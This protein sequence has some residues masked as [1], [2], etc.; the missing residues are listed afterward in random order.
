MLKVKNLRNDIQ[1]LRAIAVISVLI[2]HMNPILL[3]GG[4]L[5][6]DMFYYKII[7]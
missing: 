4:F 3:P 6:V 1:V 7:N 2:F 5:G